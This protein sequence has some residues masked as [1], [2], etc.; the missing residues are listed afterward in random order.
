[1]TRTKGRERLM[2]LLFLMDAQNDFRIEMKDQFYKDQEIVEDS[3]MEAL[4]VLCINNLEEI[5]K[6]LNKCAD[7]WTV[8]RINRVDLA[9]LRLSTAELLYMEETP[10]PVVINEAVNM[11]KK[12]GI[13]D[14]GKFVNGVLGAIYK[15]LHADK[16]EVKQEVKQEG[17]QVEKLEEN[18]EQ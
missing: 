17:V 7:N 5:D 10:T 4:F 1:M 3:F 12:Y 18:D 8:K 9:V 6:K 13:D 14:S 15:G 16:K 11:A 2:Q